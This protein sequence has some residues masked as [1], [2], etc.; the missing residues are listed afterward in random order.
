MTNVVHSSR[1]DALDQIWRV[2]GQLGRNFT[3]A[4]WPARTRCPGW[5]VAALYAHHSL[6]PVMLSAPPPP[7]TAGP[8]GEPLSAVEVLRRFNAPGGVATT[9]AET[10]A[11][12][13]VTDAA[14]HDRTEL[15]D[16]FTV[17]APQ[18][19]KGLRAADAGLLMTWPAV[20]GVVTLV[21][22]LRIVLLEAT[23]HLF[24]VFR[25]LGQ[26]P[27]A[28]AAALRTTVHLL[29]E[30]APAVELVEAATGRSTNLPLPLL[31]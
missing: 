1:L 16:R 2:W 26:P 23:V 4:Q 7:S 25:A 15:V 10:V 11:D 28:P 5:D 6:F 8:I 24:D 22:A 27:A 13:A 20:E 30:M 18:A 9:L 29:A 19:L 17:L 31:R 21:E 3:D 12:K 14:Q